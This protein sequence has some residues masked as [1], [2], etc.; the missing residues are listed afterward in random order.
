M[1]NT[2]GFIS[3]KQV[4]FDAE[5]N[6]E[7]VVSQTRPEDGRDWL[8]ITADCVGLLV[9]TLYH[10]RAATVPPRFAIERTDR[11]APRPVTAAEVSD[12]LAKTGQ[13]VRGY[14]ELVRAWWQDNLGKRPNRIRFDMAVYLSN[15]GVPDR[16]HGFG[17][18]ACDPDEALVLE[19][20]P[21][22]CDYWI[23]QLCT[24][25]QENLD[26]YE[27]G[28]GH[29]QKYKAAY[30]AD[31]SVRI[32]I[33]AEQTGIAG[34]HLDPFGHHH[35]G[36][37]LRLIG[38]EGDPPPVTLWRLPAADLRRDGEAALARVEPIISGEVA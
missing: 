21:S 11:P 34:N 10:D 36:M 12:A 32:V 25:W 1:L 31:G 7:I 5:G 19:F 29:V 27:D 23:F 35:G 38:T 9:R 13:L 6:F 4:Q 20:T 18:W 22:P 16:H 15:G 17:T 24:I 28:G 2:T 26:N 33:A 37:S 3:S 14:G 30:R 8:P